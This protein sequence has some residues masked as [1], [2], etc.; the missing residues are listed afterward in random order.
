M[1]TFFSYHHTI[2]ATFPA[3]KTDIIS[4]IE[5]LLVIRGKMTTYIGM[6]GLV[7]KVEILSD[8][9]DGKWSVKV[10]DIIRP[11]SKDKRYKT[12]GIDI[13]VGDIVKLDYGFLFNSKKLAVDY[14]DKSKK[15][16]PDNWSGNSLLGLPF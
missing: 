14:A 2:I 7:A 11:L 12:D 9:C 16:V 1:A 5:R 15:L 8:E 13:N 3:F 10:V 6:F 4:D